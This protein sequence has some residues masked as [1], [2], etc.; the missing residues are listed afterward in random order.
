MDPI[1][2]WALRRPICRFGGVGKATPS[3]LPGRKGYCADA[4]LALTAKNVVRPRRSRRSGHCG[5]ISHHPASAPGSFT[6]ILS[7]KPRSD[8]PACAILSGP[9]AVSRCREFTA[10]QQPLLEKKL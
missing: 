10:W 5:T 2:S 4:S 9:S 7:G 6:Q 8:L 1:V 3:V